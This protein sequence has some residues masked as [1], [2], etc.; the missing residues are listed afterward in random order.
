MGKA[1]RNKK[2]KRQETEALKHYGNVKSL[3]RYLK[4]ID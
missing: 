1:S 4:P 2:L 3:K